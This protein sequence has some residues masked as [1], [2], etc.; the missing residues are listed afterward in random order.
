MIRPADGLAKV[1]TIDAIRAIAH[2]NVALL[3]AKRAVEAMV[4][5]GEAYVHV[6]TI[7][8]AEAFAADLMKAGVKAKRVAEDIVDVRTLRDRL[9]LT[10][11]QFA[12]RFAIDLGTLRNREQGRYTPEA[13]AI[14]YL[15][16]IA[17]SL[18]AAAA[19]QELEI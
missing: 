14:A 18:A 8:N 1:R 11:E 10:Q 2:R 13:T 12:M 6:P 7:E 3:T 15:R 17:K 9:K 19:A 5:A 4:E 16:V